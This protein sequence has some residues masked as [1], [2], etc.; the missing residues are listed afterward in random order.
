MIKMKSTV[1]CQ[2]K[3]KINNRLIEK[4][5]AWNSINHELLIVNKTNNIESSLSETFNLIIHTNKV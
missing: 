3:W 5:Q 2:N 1:N 4:K